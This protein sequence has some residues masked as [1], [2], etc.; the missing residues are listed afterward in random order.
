MVGLRTRT[1]DVEGEG[2]H[3]MVIRC[4]RCRTMGIP[5]HVPS[6][7]LHLWS[8]RPKQLRTDRR[9]CVDRQ[10]DQAAYRGEYADRPRRV[11]ACLVNAQLSRVPRFNAM[12]GG[13]KYT[14]REGD[15]SKVSSEDLLLEEKRFRD[16]LLKTF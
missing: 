11:A 8:D 12:L 7:H 1:L 3:G 16:L 13:Q 5:G 4:T 2:A 14:S 9:E 6:G 10:R 15:W